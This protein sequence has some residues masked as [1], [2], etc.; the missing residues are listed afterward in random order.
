MDAWPQSLLIGH[1]TE[2]RRQLIAFLG[3]QR[4]QKSVLMFARKTA[5]G[6]HRIAALVGQVQRIAPAIGGVGTTFE[7]A[8]SLELVDEHDEPAWQDAQ[9]RRERLL[10]DS[11][12]AV[13]E[14]EDAGVRW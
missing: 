6:L 3:A 4:P 11:P 1:S 2:K 7:K 10:A 14:P 9:V 12:G 5:D 13:H 8:T